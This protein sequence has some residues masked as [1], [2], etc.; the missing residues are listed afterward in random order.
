MWGPVQRLGNYT[1]TNE[2]SVEVLPSQFKKR[3]FFV[4]APLVLKPYKNDSNRYRAWPSEKATSSTAAA[5]LQVADTYY[6]VPPALFSIVS[7]PIRID[8]LL[9]DK[10]KTSSIIRIAIEALLRSMNFQVQF[11]G[12]DEAGFLHATRHTHG[13]IFTDMPKLYEEVRVAIGVD[14]QWKDTGFISLIYQIDAGPRL[15][16]RDSWTE[17]TLSRPALK[18]ADELQW[19][20]LNIIASAFDKHCENVGPGILGGPNAKLTEQQIKDAK[21]QAYRNP[22]R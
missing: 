4:G 15:S 13:E 10:D 19:K 9:C 16:D 18:F 12:W 7:P 17:R 20:L 3:D 21:E 2:I 8:V 11:P 6:L 22:R 14:K 5:S 1:P